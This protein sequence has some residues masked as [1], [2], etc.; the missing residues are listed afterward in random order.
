MNHSTSKA[1]WLRAITWILRVMIGGVF[2]YA[3][4]VKFMDPAGFAVSILSYE[5]LPN[6][7]VLPLAVWLPAF[8]L[9]LGIVLLIG[10]QTRAAALGSALL[11]AVFVFA[12]SQ[13]WIRGLIIDCGCFG[14]GD[15]SPAGLLTALI[16]AGLLTVAAISLY[17]M[18]SRL[19]SHEG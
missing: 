14:A 5:L 7:V 13:A 19:R 11:G 6:L 3:G 12:L 1:A 4:A 18:A 2:L 10:I 9:V 15:A 17:V 8:E 16:R